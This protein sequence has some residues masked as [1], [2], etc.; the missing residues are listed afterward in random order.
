MNTP[1]S[2]GLASQ[3]VISSCCVKDITVFTALTSMDTYFT[4]L[5]IYLAVVNSQHMTT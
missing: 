2:E 1:E 4:Y 3:R 5:F